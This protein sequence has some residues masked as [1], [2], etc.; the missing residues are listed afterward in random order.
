MKLALSVLIL[1][2]AAMVYAMATAPIEPEL[3]NAPGGEDNNNQ[4]QNL[5]DE[6]EDG[7]G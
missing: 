2:A 3:P 1:C 4:G 5:H 6:Q 7:Q